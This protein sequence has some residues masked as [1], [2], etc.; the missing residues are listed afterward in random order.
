MKKQSRNHAEKPYEPETTES[1]LRV[2]ETE[3]STDDSSL[4]D[5]PPDT[6][7]SLPS[8]ILEHLHVPL[9]RFTAAH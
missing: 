8:A 3:L 2:A 9:V 5:T 4:S 6:T 1:L 7:N